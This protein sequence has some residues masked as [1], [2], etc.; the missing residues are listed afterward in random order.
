[1]SKKYNIALQK[2]N[3]RRGP[4][5]EIARLI[6]QVHRFINGKFEWPIDPRDFIFRQL[7]SILI[8]AVPPFG[9]DLK[10]DYMTQ[11]G[12]RPDL[13]KEEERLIATL[14]QLLDSCLDRTEFRH[15][16]AMLF[17][18]VVVDDKKNER[19][20]G[21]IHCATVSINGKT[22]KHK[23]HKEVDIGI[24]K[25]DEREFLELAECTLTYKDFQGKK[26]ENIEFLGKLSGQLRENVLPT[27]R[28]RIELIA[29]NS[30]T[31]RLDQISN[32]D[33]G[34]FLA[35]SV[36]VVGRSY[37]PGSDVDLC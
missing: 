29:A 24:D 36:K 17:E 2:H 25:L 19:A 28:V 21:I 4:R 12:R 7:K 34:D 11:F 33:L 9:L 35:A 32:F 37:F 23:N 31:S 10:A 14:Q 3:N 20:G 6:E 27:T 18:L 8:P 30:M 26:S 16:Q 15:A 13:A 1:M 5:P 22:F